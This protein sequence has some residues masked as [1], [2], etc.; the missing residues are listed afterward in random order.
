MEVKLTIQFTQFRNGG[1]VIHEE[2]LTPI[3]PLRHLGDNSDST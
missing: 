2:I 1:V 3:G